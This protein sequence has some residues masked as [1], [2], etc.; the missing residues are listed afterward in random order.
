MAQELATPIIIIIIII[1]IYIYI[2]IYILYIILLLLFC[3][4]TSETRIFLLWGEVGH[5][6][7]RDPDVRSVGEIGHENQR[8]L[9]VF[10]FENTCLWVNKFIISHA[11]SFLLLKIHIVFGACIAVSI[12]NS[13]R[14]SRP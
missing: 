14:P 8:H 10:V 1:I 13:V 4:R 2:Y 5:K 6:N 9:D 7:L 12:I 11:C 3:T